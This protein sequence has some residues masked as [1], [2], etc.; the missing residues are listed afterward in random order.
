MDYG[1]WTGRDVHWVDEAARFPFPLDSP[2]SLCGF[3]S[4]NI[5]NPVPPTPSN[6]IQ[7]N[8]IPQSSD[9]HQAIFL[10]GGKKDLRDELQYRVDKAIVK[11]QVRRPLSLSPLSSSLCLWVGADVEECPWTYRPIRP[12]TT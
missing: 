6:P 3:H 4:I 12:S 7:S 10:V 11:H 8:P 9:T 1:G 5:S 2:A